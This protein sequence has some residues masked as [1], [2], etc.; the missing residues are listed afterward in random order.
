MHRHAHPGYRDF[1]YYF[2][3]MMSCPQLLNTYSACAALELSNTRSEY[4]P[5]ALNY[6]N[7]VIK[8][9]QSMIESNSI[10]GSEDWLLIL[11]TF[12]TLVEV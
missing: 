4:L 5:V 3:L 2:T 1:S 8:G 9:V 11:I 6:Y 7:E 12:L 10:D